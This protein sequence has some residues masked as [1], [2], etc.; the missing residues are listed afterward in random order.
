MLATRDSL[1]T[2]RGKFASK[3]LWVT[4]HSDDEC[5]PAGDYTIQSEGGQ[6]LE[7]WTKCN[8]PCGAGYDPVIWLTPAATHIPRVEVEYTIYIYI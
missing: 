4:P 8:R 5:W 2:K 1:L 7:A 6:G 3:T